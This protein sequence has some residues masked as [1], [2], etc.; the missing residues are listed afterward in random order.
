[1]A[2]A[3]DAHFNISISLV[4]I[5]IVPPGPAPEPVLLP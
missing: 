4:S 2:T 1:M 5:R 3:I